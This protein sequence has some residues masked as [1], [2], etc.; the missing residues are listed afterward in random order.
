MTTP[1]PHLSGSADAA[2]RR[3][4]QTQQMQSLLKQFADETPDVTAAV[5]VTRDGL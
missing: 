3:E 2:S 1:T 5:L 4:R